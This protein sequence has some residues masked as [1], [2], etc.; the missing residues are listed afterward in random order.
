MQAVDEYIEK[1][2]TILEPGDVILT[3]TPAGRGRLEKGD[4]VEVGIE[5][6]GGRS[7]TKKAG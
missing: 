6:V 4:G 1:L 5:G 3:G 2:L 7:N